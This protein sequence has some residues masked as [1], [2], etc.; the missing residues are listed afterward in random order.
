MT[1]HHASVLAALSLSPV[2]AGCGAEP[3]ATTAERGSA[4]ISAAGYGYEFEDDNVVAPGAAKKDEPA[5]SPEVLGGRVAPEV[6]RDH[7]AGA[8]PGLR[9]PADKTIG[10]PDRRAM[11]R[12]PVATAVILAAVT[13]LHPSS[14]AA[15]PQPSASAPSPHLAAERLTLGNGLRVVLHADPTIPTVAI[16]LFYDVGSRNEARGRTGFAHMFEH[17][18]FQGSASMPRGEHPKLVVGRGGTLNAGTGPDLTQYFTVLPANELALGLWVEADRMRSLDVSPENFRSQREVVKEEVLG[19]LSSPMGRAGIR[20]DELVFEGAFSYAHPTGGLVEDLDKAEFAWI[21][22]F[23]DRYYGPDNA[24]LSIAG[25]ID[26]AA[27][28]ALVHKYFDTIPRVSP[29]AYIE[30]PPPPE[31]RAPREETMRDSALRTPGLLYGWAIPFNRHPDHY[32][33][34]L[35]AKLLG[36]GDASRL[37]RR[38]VTDNGL[39][40][41]VDVSLGTIR[42][43]PDSVTITVKLADGALLREV[44]P[45]VEEEVDK[46]AK[47]APS[48]AEMDRL[49]KRAYAGELFHLDSHMARSTWLGV[50]ELFYGN[51]TLLDEEA[52]RYQA[53]TAEDIRRVAAKYLGASRRVRIE[54]LPAEAA[55]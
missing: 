22:E 51:A 14:A 28:T 7:N 43:G 11:P 33:L 2:V 27:A 21:K 41:S 48:A 25:S 35:A 31:P 9:A 4:V 5:T 54:V 13:A 50:F 37:R 45:I 47:T 42:R 15:P 10:A 52:P 46:L 8:S 3:D 23:H 17:M 40:Q 53:V 18:M 6:I 26:V 32:P 12:S 19:G 24:V 36:D 39:A 44:E 34:A 49:H 1:T 16:S 20:L 29:P 30:P 55:K 38:L